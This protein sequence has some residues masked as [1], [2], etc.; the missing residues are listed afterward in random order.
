[1]TSLGLGIGGISPVIGF[2]GRRRWHSRHR[3]HSPRRFSRGR[4]ISPYAT[5]VIGRGRGPIRRVS[6]SPRRVFSPRRAVVS[7]RRRVVSPRR[8]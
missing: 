2:G 4:R 1:M 3:W 7:P 5:T 6:V 8:R